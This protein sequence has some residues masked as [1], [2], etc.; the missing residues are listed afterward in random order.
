MNENTL[1]MIF[2]TINITTNY[3]NFLYEYQLLY[4]K[5]FTVSKFT[6]NLLKYYK[7]Y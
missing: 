1:E 7:D 2:Y 5:L 4:S 6:T 3:I